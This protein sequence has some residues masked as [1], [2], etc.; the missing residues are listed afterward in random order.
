MLK[1]VIIGLGSIARTGHFPAYRYLEE[2]GKAKLVA[3]YDPNVKSLIEKV[4]TNLSVDFDHT[5]T[6]LKLYDNK[7][8]MLEAEQPDLVDICIPTP[9]HCEMA[10]EMLERGYHVFC[11]KPMAR[12][13][14]QAQ[15]MLA[16]AQKS[17]KKLMIGQCV[18]FFPAYTYMKQAYENG[19]LGKPVTAMFRRI[20]FPPVWGKGSWFFDYAKSGGCLHDMS[21]HDID[22]ARYLFGEPSSVSCFKKDVRCECDSVLS[23]LVYEDFN[24]HVLGDWAMEGVPM[25]IDFRVGF[26]KATL[27]LENDTLTVYNTD[28]TLYVPKLDPRNG[29]TIEL[30]HYVDWINGDCDNIENPPE[31]SVGSIRLVEVL[32]ESAFANGRVIPFKS[33]LVGDEYK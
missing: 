21:L 15:R 29:Y 31:S 33:L 24:V 17:G 2:K 28:G 27:V 26:D 10:C 6:E 30:E 22:Y 13:Y 9:Y 25:S 23:T 20:S 1:A 8:E 4:T 32:A 18:R 14:E 3:G 12:T 19:A 7:E 5:I 11:E 16:T